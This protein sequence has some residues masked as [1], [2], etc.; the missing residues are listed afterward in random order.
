MFVR[1]EINYKLEYLTDSYCK[2]D[3]LEKTSIG[4][5]T[6]HDM[7]S[8]NWKR[9]RL[10]LYTYTYAA[11]QLVEPEQGE[12]YKQNRLSDG[13][14]NNLQYMMGVSASVV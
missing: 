10:S 1:R 5:T 12:K 14:Q 9:T 13:S 6:T 3:R 8:A 2:A 7:I 4:H 11:P